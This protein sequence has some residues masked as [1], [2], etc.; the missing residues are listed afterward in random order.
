M[1]PQALHRAFGKVFYTWPTAICE[2][3]SVLMAFLVTA[4]SEQYEQYQQYEN[5]CY[6]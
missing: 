4:L 2:T 3:A 5:L 1:M 6:I